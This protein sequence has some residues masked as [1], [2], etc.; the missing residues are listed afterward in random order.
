MQA[1]KAKGAAIRTGR[2]ELGCAGIRMRREF[3]IFIIF[4]NSVDTLKN[5]DGISYCHLCV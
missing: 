5:R 2:K 1:M 4:Y 3:Y